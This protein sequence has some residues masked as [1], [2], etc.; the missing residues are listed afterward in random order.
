MFAYYLSCENGVATLEENLTELI[1][2][3]MPHLTLTLIPIG[4]GLQNGQYNT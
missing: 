4:E 2:S 1:S 3:F